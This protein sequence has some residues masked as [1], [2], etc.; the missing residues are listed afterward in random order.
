MD[1]IKIKIK[2][3]ISYHQNGDFENAEILYKEVLFLEPLNFNSNHLLGVIFIQR[4]QFDKGIELIYKAISINP[5]IAWPYNNVGNALKDI[6]KYEEALVNLN[7]AIS[8]DKNFIDAYNNRGNVLFEMKKY[9]EAIIS[10]EYA[11]LN[12]DKY[13][14]SYFNLA[15]LY[16]ELKNYK[17]A[18]YYLEKLLSMNSNYNSLIDDLL[19]SKMYIC[20]WSDYYKL[21]NCLKES[22]FSNKS[23][24]RPFSI[25]SFF[26]DPALQKS[27]A[28]KYVDFKFIE[29]KTSFNFK[30]KKGNEKICL[31]YFSS[32]F[33]EHPVGKLTQEMFQ[34]HDKNRFHL[35]GFFDCKGISSKVLNNTKSFFD[36]FININ[37][38]SDL[39]TV[40]LSR[41]LGVDIAINLN[42]FTKNHRINA[43]SHRLAPLQV[44]FLGYPG[45]LG[46]KYFDY[47]I[48]DKNI[49]PKKNRSFFNENVVY[50]SNCY[51]PSPSVRKILKS[52]TL[53]SDFLLP[54]DKF[55]F[56][57][58]CNSYKINPITFN[59]WMN[60][61]NIVKNSILWI[62]SDN[63]DLMIENL[64]KEAL[65]RNV[66]DKRIIFTSR[67]KSFDEHMSRYNFVDLFLDTY[68]FNAHS[69]ASDCL[70]AGVPILT[71][72]GQSFASR[73]ASSLLK[74]L[75]LDDLIVNNYT[76][77]ENKAIELATYPIKL[78]LLKNILKDTTKKSFLFKNN[79]YTKKIEY[80]YLEMYQK[81]TK[82]EPPSSFEVD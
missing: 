53:K 75:K 65:L 76:D 12:D 33:G 66:S 38:L 68:P 36:H 21:L 23:I 45:T 59:S 4:E 31:G 63:N 78:K 64:K 40:E 26:D 50:L 69:T 42:G 54:N 6:R 47:I 43:F 18:I 41:N 22:I 61:L 7:K 74:E 29:K 1:E 5:N 70:K 11:L 34:N 60:I 57:S 77:Y 55:I 44:N 51:M 73:V 37:D 2:E 24:H 25:L 3:A 28:E 19:H 46:S 16:I 48:A 9:K 15:Q 27:V 17:K 80:A 32:D 52:P 49:I 81:L 13:L 20:D 8:L 58:F 72:M 14:D 56:C 79:V 35:I 82:N 62:Q 71:L 67:L 30:L 39:K 10:Y